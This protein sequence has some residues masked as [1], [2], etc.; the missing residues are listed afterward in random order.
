MIEEKIKLNNIEFKKAK[1]FNTEEHVYIEYRNDKLRKM[2]FFEIINEELKD[3]IDTN[4]LK[5][6]ITENYSVEN[7]IVE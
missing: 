3:I 4:D 2:K 7:G 1:Q 6:A 5:K